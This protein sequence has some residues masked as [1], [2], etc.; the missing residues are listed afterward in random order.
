MPSSG[1][2]A[3]LSGGSQKAVKVTPAALALML[4]WK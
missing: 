2:R 4:A 1:G 3:P